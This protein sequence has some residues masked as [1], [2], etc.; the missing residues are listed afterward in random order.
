MTLYRFAPQ[1]WDDL[2]EIWRYIAA[3]DPN[4][5]DR[6]DMRSTKRAPS[7][8]NR[9]SPAKSAKTSRPFRSASGRSVVFRTI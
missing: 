9:L 1:A 6:V 2:L 4:A 7:L 3:D 5:A 8:R